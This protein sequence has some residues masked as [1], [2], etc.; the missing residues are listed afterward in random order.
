MPAFRSCLRTSL[1]AAASLAALL[2]FAA[3]AAPKTVC[4]ITVNSADERDI[5]RR[6]LPP[7]DY[8]FVEL[9]ERGRKDWLASACQQK[10]QC[11][12]LIISGHFDGGD[13]FYTDSNDK[14][15]YLTV[16][17][18]ESASC[19]DSCPG[20]FANLKEVY[21]FG[22]NTLKPVPDQHAM[23]NRDRL[24]N[25]FRNVPVIYGFS[26]KAPLGR[27]AG[28]VL[29]RWFQTSPE[30]G[31]GK[32]N[33]KLLGLFGAVSM[34]ATAGTTDNDA[35]AA[36]R[37]DACKFVD[38]RLSP[39]QK[40]EF[41]HEL[42]RR[43]V[44]E[45]HFLLEQL[46][47]FVASIPAAQRFENK[48]L[49]AFNA[50][51]NDKVA[52]E[53]FL[54]YARGAEETAVNTRMMAVARNV[55]W[56]TP[57]QEEAEFV[58]MLADRMARDRIGRDEVDL[59]CTRGRPGDNEAAF[60]TLTAGA[61]KTAKVAN[62]AA[63]ACLGNAE[64]HGR[65]LR[66]VTSTNPDDIALA[67]TYLRHRPL[68]QAGDVRAIASAIGRMPAS[69]AQVRALDTLA[70]QRLS[71]PDSLREIARLFASAK[72]VDL[73]RAIAGILI[74]SDYRVLGQAELARS[75][76]QHRIKSPGGGD[77]I[78]ALIRV[79]ETS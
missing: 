46:E 24:R 2:S 53:R 73:Q 16:S 33:T 31:S 20:V 49:G 27:Y 54:A 21:L 12:A 28:P 17:E 9:V 69:S 63:L 34:T 15:E 77:V 62:A 75:L 42:L 67:Q 78:D 51:A 36:I 5:F 56:L 13:E 60:Q 32:V 44:S 18:M 6:N 47:H 68:K 25:I 59:A 50:I 76:K 40:V 22:C 70:Q 74:R 37:A 14:S 41:L 58:R 4:T 10:V 66:A 19:S 72:S 8:K 38:N 7:G 45:V 52:R 39:A 30:I 48:T 64:A 55:G 71:D 3:N 29:D 57:A 23:S 61:L 35:Q 65:V 43:D 11:D 79:L 26:S 1:L